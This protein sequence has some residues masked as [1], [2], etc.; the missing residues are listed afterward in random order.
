MKGWDV[1][2]LLHAMML[3]LSNFASFDVLIKIFMSVML[4]M[5]RWIIYKY[6]LLKPYTVFT[7]VGPAGIISN[8]ESG[9][10]VLFEGGYYSR[11]GIIS[12]A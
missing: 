11:A 7:R 12:I 5:W 2:N 10:R 9:L 4:S 3:E 1:S 8:C 6:F